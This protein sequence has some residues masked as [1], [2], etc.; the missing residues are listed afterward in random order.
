M[1]KQVI[2]SQPVLNGLH[3]LSL[4]NKTFHVRSDV[5]VYADRLRSES[6]LHLFNAEKRVISDSL[7][8]SK[9]QC[10]IQLPLSVLAVSLAAKRAVHIQHVL[11]QEARTCPL[12]LQLLHKKKE[13]PHQAF[14]A[15]P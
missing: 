14:Y 15:Y 3:V 1:N 8:K 12:E 7:F 5:L 9:L 2:D 13:P 10:T 6:T 4:R 11:Q